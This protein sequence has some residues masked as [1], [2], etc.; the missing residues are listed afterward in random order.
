MAE[1]ESNWRY[2]EEFPR[3]T[4]ELQDAR[5][6]AAELGVEAVVP[7]VGA[8]LA[9]IA[10][11]TR[12]RTIIEIGTGTGASGLSMLAAAPGAVLTTIDAEVQ[13]QQ[14]ARAVFA[15]AGVAASRVRFITGRAL[16][17]LPRMNERSYDLVLVDADPAQVIEYVEHG[18]RLA[19][20]GG[21]VLVPHALQRGRVADPAKRDEVTTAFR[22]LLREIAG[23]D[24]VI[25]ALSPAG[26]G[27]LQLTLRAA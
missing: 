14:E 19:R 15:A 9:V 21:T 26:D 20:E 24:A 1:T 7:S 2:S 12:A 4:A 11:A 6:R 22:T 8:Q 10:A 5:A 23:S 17:V 18:L 3:E 27:L 25:S 13:H 16:D